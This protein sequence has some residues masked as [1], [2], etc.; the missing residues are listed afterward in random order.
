MV[1]ESL[2]ELLL[3]LL[4]TLFRSAIFTTTATIFSVVGALWWLRRHGNGLMRSFRR[5]GRETS[6]SFFSV[7]KI[8]TVNEMIHIVF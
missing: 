2:P 3:P 1:L 6:K 5:T 8:R 7:H 4:S